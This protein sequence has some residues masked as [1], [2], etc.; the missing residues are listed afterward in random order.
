MPTRTLTKMEMTEEGIPPEELAERP[1]LHHC[2]EWDGLVIEFGDREFDC[3]RCYVGH[4][5]FCQWCAGQPKKKGCSYCGGSKV[6]LER[7]ECPG[8]AR[9]VWDRPQRGTTIYDGKKRNSWNG[10]EM[11]YHIDANANCIDCEN[12]KTKKVVGEINEI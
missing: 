1:S 2:V 3:C 4:L 8:C 5:I 7:Y 6:L 10:V 12:N 9:E 11:V